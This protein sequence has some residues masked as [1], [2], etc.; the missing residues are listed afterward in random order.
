MNKHLPSLFIMMVLTFLL[1]SCAESALNE[2][3]QMKDSW[4]KYSDLL[5]KSADLSLSSGVTSSDVEDYLRYR[6]NIDLQN[7]ESITKYDL[8]DTNY[9]FIAQLYNGNWYLFSGDYSTA[10]LIASG[11]DGFD[12][13]DEP[14]KHFLGW[15]KTIANKMSENRLLSTKETEYNKN[16]W[17]R[18]K[19]IAAIKQKNAPTRNG[20]DPDT[21]EVIIEIDSEW[22]LDE[23]YPP[24]TETQWESGYPF[25]LALPLEPP[26]RDQ[27]RCLAGCAVTAIAQL[28]YYTHFAFGYP[29][30]TFEAASCSQYY[31][32]PGTPPYTYTLTNPSTTCWNLMGLTVVTNYNSSYAP[33]LYAYI[34][35]L[36]NTDYRDREGITSASSI[37]PTLSSLS[38]TGASQKSFSRDS[39]INEIQ[40]DRPVLCIGASNDTTTTGHMFIIDGYSWQIIRETETISDPQGHILEVN[41]ITH[42]TLQWHINSGNPGPYVFWIYSSDYYY[43]FNRKIYIGW[44]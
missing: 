5:T 6:L 12:L 31:N 18:T 19:R 23:Y 7:L 2:V 4:R 21:S 20:D 34:A 30:D 29:N 9:L 14:N 10:P 37:C 17:I 11:E 33:A 44:S 32:Q 28:V 13:T 26:Y 8:D 42:N 40:E 39:V 41:V 22:L 15:M 43:P 35:Q 38:L 3:P 25:N 24:L 16:E 27:D 1:M 36:S